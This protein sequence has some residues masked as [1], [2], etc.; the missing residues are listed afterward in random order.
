MI[1][2]AVLIVVAA[3]AV[4]AGVLVAVHEP[5]D[6]P[7]GSASHE[8]DRN[9]ECGVEPRPAGFGG[10]TPPSKA[11]IAFAAGASFWDPEARGQNLSLVAYADGTVATASDSGGYDPMLPL[12]MVGWVGPCA[13]AEA[14]NTLSRAGATGFGTPGVSDSSTALLMIDPFD[15]QN[16]S[17]IAIYALHHDPEVSGGTEPIAARRTVRAVLGRLRDT[18]EANGGLPV[19]RRYRLQRY[20]GTTAS[21]DPTVAAW[22]LTTAIADVLGPTG[23]AEVA[24][25]VV[26]ALQSARPEGRPVAQWAEGAATTVLAVSVLMP[27]EPACPPRPTPWR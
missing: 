23:C 9:D 6:G 1:I 18:A 21:T 17:T 27:G 7:L 4:S 13:V 8:V 24:P 15:A 25:S 14:R 22:P 11:V 26:D 19:D 10:A 20:E 12:P 16:R 2:G 3:V 5:G